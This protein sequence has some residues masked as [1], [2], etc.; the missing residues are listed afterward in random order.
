M[1]LSVIISTYNQ[2]QWLEKVLY[3][4]LQQTYKDFE[5]VIADDESDKETSI[6]FHISCLLS[7]F[8]R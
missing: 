6:S 7:L 1:Y 5:V 2:P 3:G 8:L 4:Y